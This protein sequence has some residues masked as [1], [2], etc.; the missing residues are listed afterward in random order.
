MTNNNDNLKLYYTFGRETLDFSLN[1]LIK[2]VVDSTNN[3]AQLSNPLCICSKNTFLSDMS[4]MCSKDLMSQEQLGTLTIPSLNLNNG[5]FLFFW[6]NIIKSNNDEELTFFKL[7]IDNTNNIIFKHNSSKIIAELN[8]YGLTENKDLINF[9]LNTR[10]L[11]SIKINK[12]GSFIIKINDITVLNSLN[13][14]L[15][16]PDTFNSFR[17][18][19]FGTNNFNTCSYFYINEVKVYDS[20]DDTLNNK[21]YN[22]GNGI[23]SSIM[24]NLNIQLETQLPGNVIGLNED[25]HLIF[26]TNL[27]RL[28]LNYELNI[29]YNN[30]LTNPNNNPNNYTKFTYLK[31]SINS[32]YVLKSELGINNTY[33]NELF[34]KLIYVVAEQNIIN[35]NNS[36]TGIKI[37]DVQDIDSNITGI[38]DLTSDALL[39]NYNLIEL[40]NNSIYN[41][42]LG[43]D[44]NNTPSFINNFLTGNFNT[45]INFNNNFTEKI[46]NIY[47][48]KFNDNNNI[49]Y[50]L[51]KTNQNIIKK[52]NIAQLRLPLGNYTIWAEFSNNYNKIQTTPISFIIK[53]QQKA[54]K[55]S[56]LP[57]ILV[58]NYGIIK[59]EQE[60]TIIPNITTIIINKKN[61]TPLQY[62]LD[63][64]KNIFVFTP[65]EQGVYNIVAKRAVE[66]Y[67]TVLSNTI[68]ILVN[69]GKQDIL[70][71]S[72]N[73][74]VRFPNNILLTVNE[75]N[76]PAAT[77]LY[78][79]HLNDID[80]NFVKMDAIT[81]PFKPTRTGNY[82][83][84][85]TRRLLNF[86]DVSSNIIN[87]SVLQGVQDSVVLNLNKNNFTYNDD[88]GILITQ[89]N[90]LDNTKTTIEIQYE[91]N[92][93]WNEICSFTELPTSYKYFKLKGTGMSKIKLTN[94]ND[95]YSKFELEK[96]IFI[97]KLNQTNI[98]LKYI[99]GNSRIK[100]SNSSLGYFSSQNPLY[101]IQNNTLTMDFDSEA[102]IYITN[103]G[104]SDLTF[105]KNNNNIFVELRNST[106]IY[107]YGN[108]AGTSTLT[109]TKLGDNI[110]NNY[111]INLD[112]IIRK[113]TQP[114]I[115][116]GLQNVPNN[117]NNYIL[118]VNRDISYNLLI[119]K[120]NETPTIIFYEKSSSICK[121]NGSKITPYKNGTC[122]VY[123]TLLQTNN[124]L[125]T[126]TR[127]INITINLIP[128]TELIFDLTSL[129]NVVIGNRINLSV[130]GG[131]I[132]SDII[133][134][135]NTPNICDIE[136]TNILKASSSGKCHI[137]ATKLGNYL[138]QDMSS[139][140]FININKSNRESS[141]ITIDNLTQNANY[142]YNL[143]IDNT[144]N[145]KLNNVSD[146]SLNIQF[147]SSKPDICSISGSIL[148]TNS[149]G[150]C[151]IRATIPETIQYLSS[152]SEI[153]N[154]TISK[155]TQRNFSFGSLPLVKVGDNINLPINGGSISGNILLSSDTSNNCVVQNNN[156]LATN[157]GICS[158]TAKLNGN[159]IYNDLVK[160]GIN[161]NINKINQPTINLQ[162][163]NTQ[164]DSSNNII[165]PIN[166]N[167]PYTLQANGC[168]ET[169]IIVYQM[170]NII[171]KDR[172]ETSIGRIENDNFYAL[173]EGTCNIIITTRETRNYKLTES[174][175]FKISIIKIN[176][177]EIIFNTIPI[178]NY[179]DT[180]SFDISSGSSKSSTYLITDSSNCS[181]RRLNV[182]G[183]NSGS[184]I[185]RAVNDGDD[186]YLP[187]RTQIVVNV[188]KINQ[189]SIKLLVTDNQNPNII[190]QDNN[191]NVQLKV[192]RN[193]TYNLSLSGYMENPIITFN[194]INN[195]SLNRDPICS[196]SGNLLIAYSE[197]LCSIQGNYTQ[198]KNYNS[199][200][201]NL[202]I[203]N[204]S[205]TDQSEI[206][207]IS[208]PTFYYNYPTFIDISG[209]ST[210]FPISLTSTTSTCTVSDNIIF[211]SDVGDCNITA[212][213]PGGYLYYDKV[214]NYNFKIT[215]EVQPPIDITISGLVADFITNAT[216]PTIFTNNNLTINSETGNNSYKNGNYIVSVS[217]ANTINNDGYNLFRNQTITSWMS[218]SLYEPQ[219][220]I[221]K[222]R[223]YTG[224]A[225]GSIL[226]G[227]YVQIQLPFNLK[228]T[229]YTLLNALNS[230]S[231]YPQTF[232]IL[233]SVDG[234]TWY[235][236]DNKNLN[237]YPIDST[238]LTN[239][240]N[241]NIFCSY[242]R[243]VITKL[244]GGDA[245]SNYIN[246]L[247]WNIYG[248]YSNNTYT[249]IVDQTKNYNLQLSN[250]QD[251]ATYTLNINTNYSIDLNN[252]VI[253]LNGNTM[254]AFNSGVCVLQANINATNKYLRTASKSIII[255]VLKREAV[256]ITTE[257]I[258]PLYFG[259]KV[260][261]KVTSGSDLTFTSNNSE[262]C[263][264]SGT[265]ISGNQSGQCNITV[266]KPETSL[267]L[268]TRIDLPLTVLKT[269]QTNFNLAFDGQNIDISDNLT[270]YVN[271]NKLYLLSISGLME[272]PNI[273]YNITLNYSID[274]NQPVVVINNNTLTAFNAGVCLL[275]ANIAETKNYRSA[276]TNP[277]LLTIIKNRQNPLNYDING[278]VYNEK[279]RL[280]I[281]GGSNTNNINI[282]IDPTS[283]SNCNYVPVQQYVSNEVK[284]AAYD[285]NGTYTGSCKLNATKSGD[286][287][288]EDVNINIP[289]VV[290]KQT[291]P[292]FDI[293]VNLEPQFNSKEKFIN[294]SSKKF[295]PFTK[296]L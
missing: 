37:I 11:F 153:L 164:I 128:Q 86:Q 93:E 81:Y 281:S 104:I 204:V 69:D 48:Y 155:Q 290:N 152:E 106:T 24:G 22:S 199:G 123:A 291:Q 16:L 213:K 270:L 271:R 195:Y 95:L 239:N 200:N 179:N 261:L 284:Y 274:P 113:I 190:V 61:N 98:I 171:A 279:S 273:Q 245:N 132:N 167:Q 289:L 287:N 125:Q 115:N 165:I 262:N 224:Y 217:S 269:N 212:T 246:L 255:T 57:L 70:T 209:G 50:F 87:V 117:N 176:Q 237:N 108:S 73:V 169:P 286:Y 27:K 251:N 107:I 33:S 264:I 130:T 82:S 174:Q 83:F 68:S 210:N 72:A 203:V 32:S 23:K 18:I 67:N 241:S 218:N 14:I 75:T 10:Y 198:T 19:I 88:L 137:T 221:Y 257:P 236:L 55:I 146:N 197:G 228:L 38:L 211:T 138:Y 192:N 231:K 149:I 207:L 223:T 44:M 105:T 5:L 180:V 161:I 111:I 109:L 116:I 41:E 170:I 148:K 243:L 79:K 30:T 4:F 13:I 78:Y 145:L 51:D 129:N 267:T 265:I 12:N 135:S 119:S 94:N 71:I 31:D 47:T 96:P 184:C 36:S 158:L 25:T 232:Y 268:G 21:I 276:K 8:F 163:D 1:Y 92:S 101:S 238:L 283:Q 133:L 233:G 234:F 205:K 206:N 215:Q 142:T 294:V 140:L 118:D 225:G 282:N 229:S 84:Y 3:F 266:S 39:N 178:L 173:K 102:L 56:S 60:N 89:Q 85:A 258:P 127:P 143:I 80:F 230:S 249:L 181:C 191:G 194:I 222:G 52:L 151:T 293:N 141:S 45:R 235:L 296:L 59:I 216:I 275:Q 26:T 139:N 74:N 15:L 244:K 186:T 202:I 134:T 114:T 227:E 29:F 131:S 40:S 100:S 240:V 189:P 162:I 208:T 20:I 112:I 42:L 53:N 43:N 97:S 201:T 35:I 166:T 49:Y 248:I 77:R 62:I 272:N 242:F 247:Q 185:I 17:D 250:I 280:N 7:N 91:N 157:A 260:N 187:T 144:Y 124:Y 9:N 175:L 259:S 226:F 214:T 278:L 196:I 277:I 28:P 295:A 66:G 150:Q 103:S 177:P 46:Y 154:I 263:T 34:T 122:E 2:N 219:T 256:A 76:I 193:K 126:D 160:S 54:L 58:N 136:G 288:Y 182:T 168:M 254:I 188:N 252:P 110:Y 90:R 285:I 156:I 172:S 253:R 292:Q 65:N 99:F 183:I 120:Y 220:G 121:I 147:I 64:K 6:V 159:N 63:A